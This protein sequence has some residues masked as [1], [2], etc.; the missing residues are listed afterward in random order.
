[1]FRGT[2][3]LAALIF[4]LSGCSATQAYP[5]PELPQEQVAI[6]ELC[7]TC[8]L[9]GLDGRQPPSSS[10]SQWQVLPGE[11]TVDVTLFEVEEHQG[12]L[13]VAFIAKPG[14]EYYVDRYQI[15]KPREVAAPDAIMTEELVGIVVFE[16]GRGSEKCFFDWGEIR[17]G[18]VL[19]KPEYRVPEINRCP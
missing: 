2:L 19:L 11:H 6:I 17:D 15:T 9:E 14:I 4:G 5:G 12:T 18:E 16:G 7:P 13:Q 1:M 8:Q 3:Q 10:S